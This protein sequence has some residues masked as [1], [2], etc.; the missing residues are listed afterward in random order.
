PDLVIGGSIVKPS[1]A[2]KLVGIWLDEALTWKEQAAVAVA[3]G[4]EWIINFR[5]LSQVAGGVGATYIRQLYLAIC[6]PR[7]LYGAE[8]WLA[9]V[10]QRARG[11]NRR[12]DTRAVI[13]KIS[14]I[15]LR[16]ARLMLGGMVSSPGDMLNAHADLLP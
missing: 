2:V 3:K 9:P 5:R 7:M 13:K 12:K 14:S 6:V 16:A 8:V 11:V 1:K 10:R 4:Q 15:Q